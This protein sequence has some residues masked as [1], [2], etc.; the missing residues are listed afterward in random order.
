M[1]LPDSTIV[2]NRQ[3]MER[4]DGESVDRTCREL[5]RRHIIRET[6][7]EFV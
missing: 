1:I 2:K 6:I 4:T 5:E 7:L 3:Y